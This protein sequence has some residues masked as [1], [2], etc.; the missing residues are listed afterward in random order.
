MADE[1][2]DRPVQSPA[3][4]G[5]LTRTLGYYVPARLSQVEQ[6]GRRIRAMGGK[7]PAKAKG[8]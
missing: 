5:R 8:K 4:W 3:A 1:S 2:D 7:R 6:A